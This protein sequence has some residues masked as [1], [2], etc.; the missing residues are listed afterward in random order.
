M[1]TDA[2]RLDTWLAALAARPEAFDFYQALRHIEALHPQV[3]RLG[4]ALRPADEPLRIGQPA[5]LGFAPAALHSLDLEGSQPRL[6]QRV[7]GLLGPNGPLPVHISELAR[8]R[9]LHHGDE[10]L[11]RFLDMLTHRFAL[12]FYRAWAQAQPALDADRPG[13]GGFAQRLA[14]LF[15]AG[16]DSLRERDAA[17]DA[18][19]LF[20]TGRLARQVRDA[21]GLTH[22]CRAVFDAPM[23]IVQWQGRWM[24]LDRADRTR[25]RTRRPGWPAGAAQCLGGGAA[26]GGSIWDVQHRFRVIAGPLR[27][28]AY[29]ALLPGGTDLARLR[30]MVRQW[31]GLEFAWDLRLILARADVPRL[32]LGRA[33]A[34]GRDAWLGVYRREGDADDLVI[35]VENALSTTR[36]QAGSGG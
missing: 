3:P 22:W 34:L 6:M 25:L 17:G 11:Q 7:F 36:H 14:S 2:G 4:E 16:L 28:A 29:R 30:A 24:P 9:A 12:L 32:V 33:G 15:G 10:T 13:G 35:D 27:S 20:F 19:K 26:L 23:R 18:A 31:V 1:G 5:S 8:E 21:D